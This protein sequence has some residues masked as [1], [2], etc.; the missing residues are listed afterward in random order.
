MSITEIGISKKKMLTQKYLK[1][2]L[3]LVIRMDTL[4]GSEFLY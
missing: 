1:I 4:L 2:E 3:K